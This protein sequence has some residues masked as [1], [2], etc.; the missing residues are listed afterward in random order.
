MLPDRNISDEQI[1]PPLSDDDKM[2]AGF[3][4]PVWFAASPWVLLSNKKNEP[5][6]YFHALQ[7]LFIGAATTVAS[8]ISMLIIYLAFSH[9]SMKNLPSNNPDM[10]WQMGCGLVSILVFTVFLVAVTGIFFVMLWLGGKASAGEMFK[11]PLLGQL[12]YEYTTSKFPEE[13]LNYLDMQLL[14]GNTSPGDYQLA[15]IPESPYSDISPAADN[16]NT[17]YILPGLPGQDE[18]KSFEAEIPVDNAVKQLKTMFSGTDETVQKIQTQTNAETASSYYT[19][20]VSEPK[21]LLKNR[22]DVSSGSQVPLKSSQHTTPLEKLSTRKTLQQESKPD[23]KN[24]GD[25]MSA[26]PVYSEDPKVS[27]QPEQVVTEKEPVQSATGEHILELRK[28]FNE[29]QKNLAET[30]GRLPG[31]GQPANKTG[32]APVEAVMNSLPSEQGELSERYNMARQKREE[33]EARSK[34]LE[35]KI[36]RREIGNSS[37]QSSSHKEEKL[38]SPLE[39]L[40]RM[41]EERKRKDGG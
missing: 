19:E 11:V 25:K 23:D 10:G 27:M 38:L 32:T 6:L 3:C 13:Y 30:Q 33:L 39:K 24:A 15:P 12:A 21:K 31:T 40:A 29:R 8:V 26:Y 17:E 16:R 5:F 34:D 20:S 9:H 22:R 35:E 37:K 1:V 28:K 36:N 14:M 4:Y 2:L 18:R 7:S 41:R